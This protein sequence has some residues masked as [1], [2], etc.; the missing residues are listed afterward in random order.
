MRRP[1]AALAGAALLVFLASVAAST[2][3]E[4]APPV[5]AQTG[6]GLETE[7]IFSPR[8]VNV[9]P[10]CDTK[11]LTIKFASFSG[12]VEISVVANGTGAEWL[13][14]PDT[15]YTIPDDARLDMP[16]SVPA[17]T[18]DG[19]Y[20]ILFRLSRYNV[21]QVVQYVGNWTVN[22]GDNFSCPGGA[23][24]APVDP[25][26]VDPEPVDPEPV[27]PEPVDPEPVDPEPV[28]PE[29]VDPEGGDQTITG[30]VVGKVQK[31][32]A[33][34]LPSVGAPGTGPT[35][36]VSPPSQQPLI[37]VGGGG[38]GGRGGGGGAVPG[39]VADITLYSVSWDC[40][41]DVTR[42]VTSEGGTNYDVLLFSA[43]GRISA[44]PAEEQD[45][46]GRTVFE[47]PYI[48]DFFSL[49][50]FAVDGRS[51]QTISK[52]VQSGDVCVGER[53]FAQY[54]GE[55]PGAEAAARPVA[56]EPPAQRG[57]APF[58]DPTKDPLS[59][60]ERYVNDQTYRDW[61]DANYAE[62]YGSI[63]AAVGLA[64][65]CVERYEASLAGATAPE[66]E[67]PA[68]EAEEPE[69]EEPAPEAE[70]PEAEE[71]A[72]EA[73]EPEA[74]EPAPEAEEPE[75]EEPAPEAE[76]E[77]SGCLVATAA[78]GTELA[79]QLQALREVR[80][81]TLLATGSGTAFMSA[82]NTAYYAF[83]PAVADMERQNPLFRQAVQAAITPMVATLSAVMPLAAQDGQADEH[84]VVLYGVA[85]LALLA[86]MYVAAPAY[87]AHRVVRAARH[88]GRR[89]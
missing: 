87:A 23:G 78:Y 13:E 22:V 10:G 31:N 47:A 15:P 46:P 44:Q 81:G 76:E 86:G 53:I 72:P 50:L 38:G 1:V 48:D 11:V 40:N 75:A 27:D 42:I 74:E 45:L 41:E 80:D 65:G 77:A 62:E 49:R 52:T 88:L 51:V 82:F 33:S 55:K 3:H 2:F 19:E 73:E 29:P 26:P 61:F 37:P 64:E 68:P 24:P 63:C 20:P 83:S 57:I 18:A 60:V 66:A 4:I 8:F 30:R 79:P 70:E 56:P 17:G 32:V 39:A 7:T 25:E 36:P 43:Q 84:A 6:F 69:A 58:V 85:S 89:A 9:P 34:M 59:Y 35:V 12:G 67:E 16:V 21:S 28:D 5:A 54:V 14:L 71:P